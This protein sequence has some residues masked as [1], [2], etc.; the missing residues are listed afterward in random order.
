ML[1]GNTIIFFFMSGPITPQGTGLLAVESLTGSEVTPKYCKGSSSFIE[2]IRGVN[3]SIVIFPNFILQPGFRIAATGVVLELDKSMQIVKKLK[4]T[5]TPYKI[6]KKTAFVQVH[7]KSQQHS[8][9]FHY[10]YSN[11][12]LFSLSQISKHLCACRPSQTQS[13]SSLLL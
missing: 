4:L 6:Y 11:C 2:N 1:L 5:G 12:P 3:K 8:H 9:I 13:S 10:R 7:C